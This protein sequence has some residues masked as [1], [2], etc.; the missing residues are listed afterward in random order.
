MP[1]TEKEPSVEKKVKTDIE[2]PVG[3]PLAD[4]DTDDKH[5]FFD[6]EEPS[7]S[8]W[9]PQITEKKK[10][11]ISSPPSDQDEI[12]S[13]DLKAVG[14]IELPKDVI[15]A[16]SVKLSDLG[17]LEEEWDELDFYPLHEPFAYIE[18]LREKESLDKCYFLVEI[19][20]TE[21]EEN[22][23]SFIMDTMASLDI[24]TLELE[25]K[26]E[27]EYL[28]EIIDQIINEYNIDIDYNSRK[29]IFYY[30][31]KS[32]LGLGKI[33]PLMK[34]PDIEDISCDGS[35]VPIFLY[36]RKYGSLK[37]NIRFNDED[38]LTSFVSRL[39]QKCGKH[40][41]IAEPML[42]ATMPDGSRIQM[43]LSDEITAKGSTFTIRKFRVYPFSP[44]ELIDN[45][46]VSLEVMSY[47]WFAVENGASVLVSGGTGT[48]K[49][50]LLNLLNA[51]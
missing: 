14:N 48:G 11:E 30:L 13:D 37:S 39:A 27:G 21:E 32:S 40:I 9:S 5:A 12:D 44:V 45:K 36:H 23:L 29:K 6:E 24:D 8:G 50:S 1:I 3:V 4:E 47:L 43:T 31:S 19:T 42:D 26:S 41:S 35:G 22:I 28:L 2:I 49:T 38:E 17:F 51:S 7:F 18:I 10:K 25:E 46:T 16:K 34:D 20:L 15:R 33:D